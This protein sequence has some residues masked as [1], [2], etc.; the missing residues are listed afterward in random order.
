MEGFDLDNVKEQLGDTF[1]TVKKETGEVIQ[2]TKAA[3]T[4]QELENAHIVGEAGYRE[5]AKKEGNGLAI[6]SLVLGI[7]SL[8]WAFVGTLLL[9]GLGFVFAIIGVVLGAVA[10]KQNQTSMATAGFVCSLIGLILG[11]INLVCAVACV[12][13]LAA[14][15]ETMQ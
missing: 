15:S 11:V 6:A 5:Q 8:I 9:P 7:L 3:F 14:L 1:D 12:G 4:G 2:E 13:G 10:R